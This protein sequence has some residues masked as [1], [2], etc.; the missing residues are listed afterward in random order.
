[1]RVLGRRLD[2]LRRRG[3]LTYR[4]VEQR[5]GLS[6]STVQYL[7]AKR[8]SP[9]E[10]YELVALVE[11]LGGSWDADWE[12]LWQLA[13]GVGSASDAVPPPAPAE[14][15]PDVRG[16]GGRAAELSVLDSLLPELR[17]GGP[18][19]MAALSGTAGVGKTALALHWAHRRR[20]AFPD[21]R[22]HVDLHGYG[23]EPALPVG[24]ALARLLTG[25]GHSEDLPAGTEQ[26]AALLRTALDGRRALL[27]LD[28][29]EDVEQ[30]RLL[31]PGSGTCL[32]LV[33][34]RDALAGLVARYGARRLPVEPLPAADAVGL[35]GTLVGERVATAPDAAVALAERCDR[36]PLALRVA[37]ELAAS[38]PGVPLADLVAELDGRD[39]LELLDAGGDPRS[40]VRAVLSWSYAQLPAGAARTFRLLGSVPGHPVDPYG[41]AALTG[42]TPAE[43]RRDLATLARASLVAPAG[44]DR[45][46]MHDL[47]RSYAAGLA[48]ADDREAA[49]D[50]LAGHL[51][52]AA[53]RATD[54]LF[55]VG[56]GRPRVPAPPHP[57]PAP[58]DPAAALAWLDAE[59]P[60]LVAVGRRAGPALAEVLSRYLDTGGHHADALVVHR[61]ARASASAAGDAA[62]EAEAEANLGATAAGRGRFAEAVRHLSRAL[63]LRTD[64]P[65]RASV[66]SS[67]GAVQAAA[68][69]P[70][71][72]TPYLR[73]ALA[74]FAGLG[75]VAG[76]ARVRSNLSGVAAAEGRLGDAG[77]EL[78]R[79]LALFRRIDDRVGAARALSNLGD[80]R[81]RQGRYAEAVAQLAEALE[82]FGDNGDRV[83]T[84]Y[85][86]HGLAD[87]L[88]RQGRDQEAAEEYG[89]ALALFREI[90]D[91]AGEARTAAALAAQVPR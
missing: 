70:A 84:A 31:L 91:E 53:A 65:G 35:L 69:E 80:V 60:A 21:G 24:E 82:L 76:E 90:G 77:D 74:L 78:E 62:A 79:A 67:L 16:F 22:L 12:R 52:D 86:R 83:G 39:P 25:L 88:A 9:P 4:D 59:R 30:V 49:L 66:L 61:T 26:R 10:Y 85:T 56:W 18:L 51:L 32:V 36:L 73:T 42:S 63:E 40:G 27:L 15:P 11:R 48:A 1:M 41:T 29:A 87:L 45:Y 57:R 28:N 23:P 44:A 33:T 7:V 38:R 37:A 6:R 46:G 5:T 47:L 2:A 20:S 68:G 19:V 75:D 81:A 64:P 34:S 43:A 55:G 50:R 17:P 3:G 89:R 58:A 72:A 14:L 71:A 54:V 13:A 8:T